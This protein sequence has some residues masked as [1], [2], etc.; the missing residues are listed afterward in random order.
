MWIFLRI[1]YAGVAK[2]GQRRELVKKHEA[3]KPG[4]ETPHLLGVRGFKSHLPHY[5]NDYSR[6]TTGPIKGRIKVD[7]YVFIYIIIIINCFDRTW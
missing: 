2:P 5:M 4:F 3:Q 1:F 6:N 7:L